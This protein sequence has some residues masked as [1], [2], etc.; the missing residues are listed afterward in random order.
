MKKI[1]FT[2]ALTIFTLFFIQGCAGAV[3]EKK[4]IKKFEEKDFGSIPIVSNFQQQIEK[5]I[6][7]RLKDPYSAK[8]TKCAPVPLKASMYNVISGWAT[9]CQVNAKNSYGGYTGFKNYNAFIGYSKK[10]KS[11]FLVHVGPVKEAFEKGLII[12]GINDK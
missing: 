4:E 6:K 5:K 10:T 1:I 3:P 11:H 2:I 8:I 7:V 9:V 12:Y